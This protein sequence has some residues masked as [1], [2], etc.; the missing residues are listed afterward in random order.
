[1]GLRVC[2]SKPINDLHGRLRN[3]ATNYDTHDPHVS[4][5]G[6]HLPVVQRTLGSKG[7]AGQ[8]TRTSKQPGLRHTSSFRFDPSLSLVVRGQVM[9]QYVRRGSEGKPYHN[10][11]VLIL[12]GNANDPLGVNLEVLFV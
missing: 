6:I 12:N 5:I 8:S 1:M 10:G 2:R 3:T 11:S 7:T 4:Y 9:V